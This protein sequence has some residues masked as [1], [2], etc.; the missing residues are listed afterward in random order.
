MLML[1]L[2]TFVGGEGNFVYL[3]KKEK[4]LIR[5]KNKIILYTY[6][7]ILDFNTNRPF[8]LRY[9]SLKNGSPH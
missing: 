6:I 9:R 3:Y 1:L 5:P 4:P 8:Y 2:S 7:L